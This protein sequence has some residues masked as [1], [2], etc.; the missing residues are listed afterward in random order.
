LLPVG[1]DHQPRTRLVFGIDSLERLGEL[2]RTLTEGRVLLVTDPGL[3]AAGHVERALASLRAAG[4]EAVVHAGVHENPTTRDVDECLAVARDAGISA[5]IG[6]GGGS[7]LDTAK[8]CNF[9]LTN[10]GRMRDYWGTG[11][12]AR[13]MLP[14]VAVP[15]TAGTGSECQSFALIADEE[16]HQKMA[17]GD[18][19]AA[20]AVALLDPALTVSQPPRVT[21][22]TGMDAL[23]HALETAVTRRR[24]EL[25]LL[26]S[27]EAFRLTV[28][29]LERVAAAPEDLA[30]RA[31]MLLGAAYAGIAIEC[32]MLGA[33]HSSAN[34][35]TARFGITHGEA[36]GMM[37]PHV[38]RYNGADPGAAAVYRELAGSAGLTDGPAPEALARRVAGILAAL[39]L[40]ATP[41]AYGAAAEH[42]PMLA[43]EAAQQ[44]TAR[45]NPREVGAPDFAA[46]YSQALG[47][48][49]PA[50]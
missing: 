31:A 5:I 50:L 11:K 40:E 24:N 10:G 22:C 27:R 19:K 2:T 48:P 16:T 49:P 43:A 33:A 47:V 32:S 38:I 28:T 13:P 21:A 39:R 4:L 14:L 8:G 35:L 1:F 44:W 29:H 23:A 25:S 15:T 18:P 30:A 6:F 36:V 26:Y 17:C 42:V 34:P 45:F 20:P 3:V 46:L 12:A 41:A 37:L 9:L 7:S